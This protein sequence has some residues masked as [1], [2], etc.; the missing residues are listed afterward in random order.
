MQ[1]KTEDVNL[2]DFGHTYKRGDIYPLAHGFYAKRDKAGYIYI[3][4]K[5][6]HYV[7]NTAYSYCFRWSDV[8]SLAKRLE[9]DYHIKILG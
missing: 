4:D 3:H 8:P 9:E 2:D 1:T 6:K 7:G 5:N